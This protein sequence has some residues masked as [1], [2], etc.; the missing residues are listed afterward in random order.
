MFCNL[1]GIQ[2]RAFA[3]IVRYA[4]EIE[5]VFNR[6]ILADA[7][8]ID[9]VF[10]LRFSRGGIRGI[11]V[12]INDDNSRSLAQDFAGF[13]GGN[14]ALELDIDHFRVT[15]EYGHAHA[16]RADLD[17][18]VHD[19]FRFGDHLPFFLGHAVIHEF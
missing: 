4:P 15:D 8:D 12:S 6:Y 17:R 14:L 7:A 2:R 13:V 9:G 5:T 16:R 11:A 1:D 3:Q 18:W 19:L 10:T